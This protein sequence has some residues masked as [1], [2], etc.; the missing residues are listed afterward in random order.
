MINLPDLDLLAYEELEYLLE[1]LLAA[2]EIVE[3]LLEQRIEDGEQ[4]GM[5][6]DDV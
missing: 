5:E 1:E 4:E 3:D 2:Q 6:P